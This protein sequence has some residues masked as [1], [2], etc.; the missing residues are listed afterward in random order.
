MRIDR[1][2][3]IIVCAG[4]LIF[5]VSILKKKTTVFRDSE[6][7]ERGKTLSSRLLDDESEPSTPKTR[8]LKWSEAK[9]DI[10]V[11]VLS[12]YQ[13]KPEAALVKK[14][15]KYQIDQEKKKSVLKDQ[16]VFK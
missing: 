6:S 11:S 1:K 5:S 15:M 8:V 2:L 16:K 12:S 9:P 10:K 7:L 3:L 14:E 4:F 13:E